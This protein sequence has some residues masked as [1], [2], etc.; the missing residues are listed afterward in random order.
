[1]SLMIQY[2]L[3]KILRNNPS[4]Q[5]RPLN[6]G[7]T[8]SSW[9]KH[10]VLEAYG[11]VM[12]GEGAHTCPDTNAPEIWWSLEERS[13]EPSH[14]GRQ[15]PYLSAQRQQ[16]QDSGLG[17]SFQ[18]HCL[19]D[20]AGGAQLPFS[21]SRK[22]VILFCICPIPHPKR[23]NQRRRWGWGRGDSIALQICH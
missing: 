21:K 13:K 1:M 22:T 5:K 12:Q 10:A 18:A 23:E 17:A 14:F 16:S 6:L 20:H 11:T 9:T 8:G 2:A 19:P 15:H 4:L 3:M 7:E